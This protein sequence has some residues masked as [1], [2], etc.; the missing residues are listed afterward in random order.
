MEHARPAEV[1][2]LE[3]VRPAEVKTL[4]HARPAEVKTLEHARCSRLFTTMA[5][6]LYPWKNTFL[7][8][9]NGL[10]INGKGTRLANACMTAA[11]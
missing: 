3:H 6:N 1:K 7:R 4:E 8:A 11:G 9:N 2:T 5:I 10:V